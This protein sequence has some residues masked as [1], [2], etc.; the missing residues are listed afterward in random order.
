LSL[1][2]EK[3]LHELKHELN[4]KR[5]PWRVKKN[6]LLKKAKSQPQQVKK[7]RKKKIKRTIRNSHYVILS[8]YSVILSEVEEYN[9]TLHCIQSDINT[10]S[11]TRIL[12][13][14]M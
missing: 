11:D 7:M 2:N 8:E 6:E 13:F 1:P 9:Y 14:Y 10:Q 5:P 12:N 3:L 4:E